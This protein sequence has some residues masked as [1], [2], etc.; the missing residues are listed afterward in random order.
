M[1]F[2]DGR[3]T[4]LAYG[5][6]L[7]ASLAYLLIHQNDMAGLVTFDSA[8]RDYIPPRGS[9]RHLRAFSTSSG[10][11]RPARQTDVPRVCHHLAE[12]IRSR[13]MIVLISDL[14][15]DEDRVLHALQ[16]FHHMKHDVIVF[17]VLDGSELELRTK[18]SPTSATSSRA[19]TSP[20]IPPCS[21]RN[22]ASGCR[23]TARPCAKAAS[24]AVPSYH[25]VRTSQPL[26]SVL[27]EFLRFR[28][29]R[30]R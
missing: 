28:M 30:S 20:S 18:S 7:A 15:E 6:Y 9:R 17:H 19:G 8:V 27:A 11:S 26:E 1:D 14:L 16:H 24:A 13:G 10:G 4:K 29:R 21:A 5:S 25:L 22:T 2:G 3:L 12:T 23:R